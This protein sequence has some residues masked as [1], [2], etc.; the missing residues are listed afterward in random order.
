[1]NND[2][3]SALI[4]ILGVIVGV[5]L[6]YFT[7]KWRAEEDREKNFKF[8][9]MELRIN[10][11]QT[12]YKYIFQIY[13]AYQRNREDTSRADKLAKEAR[14]WLDGQILILGDDIHK[15]VFTYFNT[16]KD[17]NSK[18]FDL[19]DDAQKK[20]KKVLNKIFIDKL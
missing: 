10:A 8:R 14:D 7:S 5:F 12:A 13:R 11:A 6:Q 16:A 20:L 19:M 1:M 17:I 9:L 15:A 3:L 2:T 4:A 18:T